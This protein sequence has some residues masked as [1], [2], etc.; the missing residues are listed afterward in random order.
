MAHHASREASRTSVPVRV[1]LLGPFSL[2]LGERLAGPWTRPVAKRLCV[3]VVVNPGRLV[4]R[5]AACQALFPNLAPAEA[6]KRLSVALSLARTGLRSLGEVGQGLLRVDRTHIW[7]DPSCRLEVDLE[8]QEEMLRSALNAE[9]GKERDDLLSLAL[10]NEQPLLEEEPSAEWAHQL[11]DHL[12]WARQEARLTLARDRTRGFGRCRPTEVVEAW[13]DSL[14]HDLTS[15]EAACALMRVYRAQGKHASVQA[16]YR[17]CRSA[18]EQLGL[19]PSPALEEVHG[20][21][22]PAESS[23]SGLLKAHQ[24]PL[25]GHPEEERRLVS[26]L[27]AE[28]SGTASLGRIDPEDLHD[29]VGN[30]IVTLISEVER[31]GGTVTSVS[32]AGLEALFGAPIAHEDDPERAVRAGYRMLSSLVEDGRLSLRA[33]VETGPAVVGPIGRSAAL[34][35][36]AIGEAVALAAALQSVARPASVLV[37]PVTRSATEGLFEWGPTEE[38]LLSASTK[39]LAASYLERPKA[40]PVGQAGRRGLAG[41]APLVGRQE[42]LSALRGALQEMTAGKGSV[43]VI[44]G[45]A[46][47][48]KTRLVQECR[49]IFMAWVGAASGRLP[50]WLEG[51]AASYA[52]SKPYGLYQQLL[53]AWVGVAPDEG[54]DR[55][56]AA[57]ERALKALFAGQANEERVVVLCHL[58]ALGQPVAAGLARLGPE[59]LQRATFSALQAVVGQ[60]I[61]YGPTV[62]VLE[63]LHWADP[64]SLRL[65]TEMAA[66]TKKGPLWLVL[67]R[68]PEPDASVS[69]LEEALFDDTNIKSRK[70]ELDPLPAELTHAL[71]LALLG[72]GA[73]DKVASAVAHGTEGNPLFLEER[74]S[75]LIEAGALTRGETGWHLEP[76]ATSKLPEAL[77]RLVRSRV[78][79]LD[80]G[81]REAVAAASV[82]GL[83]FSLGALSVTSDLGGELAVAVGALCSGGLL[84]ELRR[85]PEPM[86]R[87]RHALI[88]EATYRGLLRARRRQLHARAAWGLEELLSGRLD[89]AAGVIGHH[90]DMAGENGRAAHYLELAGDHAAEAFAND[91]ALAFYRR[92]LEVLKTEGEELAPR[93]AGVASRLGLLLWRT[94]RNAEGRAVLLEATELCPVPGAVALAECYQVLAKIEYEDDG[95]DASLVAC[96]RAEEI[97]EADRS[98]GDDW[99]AAWVEVQLNRCAVYA[100]R[101]QPDLHARSLGRM[102]PLAEARAVPAQ[103]ARYL[104]HCAVQR[105]MEERDR[106]DSAHQD[107]HRASWAVVKKAGLQYEMAWVLMAIGVCALARGDLAEAR[108]ALDETAALARRAGETSCE[109]RCTRS[110]AWLGVREHNIDF[111]EQMAHRGDELAATR[112]FP[113]HSYDGPFAPAALAWVAWKKRDYPLVERLACEARTLCAELPR[114]CS[115]KGRTAGDFTPATNFPLM[116]VYLQQGRNNEAIDLARELLD[117]SVP[118]FAEP[119]EDALRAAVSYSEGRQY[120]EAITAMHDVLRIAEEDRWM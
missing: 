21:G 48:G 109:L 12:N 14:A 99:V 25:P 88:Q 85:S 26:V 27:F 115:P 20:D 5:A 30:A 71:A 70:L 9:P 1:T 96:D 59:Q 86:Y 38:L 2:A 34:D 117:P 69:A 51:R 80:R 18:L 111:V 4:T 65:T 104:Y 106:S 13:E 35:Y 39:P 89:E 114:T 91:E 102:R 78:D 24:T 74:L 94:G 120:D 75:S 81:Q 79:G 37:G 31:L 101:K 43:A 93:A 22:A 68:R 84:V 28:L 46:G 95:Y 3:L 77:E 98:D 103:K 118:I 54:A 52:S 55:V 45:E 112:S 53:A 110:L 16:T 41:P 11:R 44:S 90:F 7:V 62:L 108:S 105:G 83:D 72:R 6:A 40:R 107:Y 36:G 57:L 66:I 15:E 29:L 10:G 17:R 8:V 119:L 61:T 116:A 23:P 67:T 60:L 19:H 113:P 76:G 50:L 58:M 63:D 73:D 33:G 56:R 32:G 92:A 97:L 100:D 42:E 47:L 82:L 49:K 64:T 87:F